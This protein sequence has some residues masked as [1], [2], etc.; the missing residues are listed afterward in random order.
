M[1]PPKGPPT[2]IDVA[3]LVAEKRGVSIAVRPA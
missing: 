2:L 3:H 1:A